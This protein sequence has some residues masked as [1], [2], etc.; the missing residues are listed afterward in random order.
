LIGSL[1]REVNAMYLLTVQARD[2]SPDSVPAS[3]KVTVKVKDINDNP[4]QITV[5]A[6]TR[7]GH[8]EVLESKPINSFV[9]HLSV[10]DFDE[11]LNGQFSCRLMGQTSTFRLEA[12]S[13]S[14]Y[15]IVT[16]TI[17]DRERYHTYPLVVTCADKGSPPLS[18]SAD[19]NVRV[20]DENDNSPRFTK[21]TYSKIIKENM[22][23]GSHVLRVFATDSD[24]G[25]NGH[26]KYTLEGSDSEYFRINHSTGAITIRRTVD[27]EL[28]TEL[29]FH[30]VAS[31]QGQPQRSSTATVS[32][33]IMDVND[34]PPTFLQ[35]M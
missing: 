14:G 4:P 20:L 1:D 9:A 19:I 28:T 31:D 35:E 27:Y 3:V 11:G 25:L 8:V 33:T 30:V 7:T 34:E 16:N 6:L 21:Q 32:L 17:L 24:L 18:S 5:N 13:R 29:R 23:L 10:K 22:A 26:V 2:R 12:I 15:K